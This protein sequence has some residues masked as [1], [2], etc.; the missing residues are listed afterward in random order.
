MGVVADFAALPADRWPAVEAALAF[1]GVSVVTAGTDRGVRWLDCRRDGCAV[2]L[3]FGEVVPGGGQGVCLHSP[4]RAWWA[5]PVGMR[6]LSRAVWAAVLAAGG[7][8]A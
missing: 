7:V 4:A 5:R 3:A 2:S 6:R 1:A 8:P